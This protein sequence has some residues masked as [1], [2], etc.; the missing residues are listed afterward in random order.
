MN[1]NNRQCKIVHDLLPLYKEE[2]THEVTNIFIQEHI[3]KC[4]TCKKKLT[5]VVNEGQIPEQINQDKEIKYLENI[6]RRALTV[7]VITSIT[8]GIFIL[9]LAWYICKIII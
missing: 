7:I 6:R 4:N 5:E 2:L 1:Q 9:G 3:A 8:I